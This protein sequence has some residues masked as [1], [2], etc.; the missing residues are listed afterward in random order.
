MKSYIERVIAEIPQFFSH[1]SQCLFRP[2]RFIQAELAR[3]EQPD[4]ISKGVEFLILSF[5]IALF[6]SQV[7]PEATNPLAQ[8]PQDDAAFIRLAGNALFDLFMLFFAAA[9]CFGC[10]RMAGLRSSFWQFFPLFAFFAGVTLVLLV[11]ANALTNIGFIDPYVARNHIALEQFATEFRSLTEQ[12]LCF[13]DPLTG[14]LDQSKLSISA[15]QMQAVNDMQQ[16][17]SAVAQRPLAQLGLALQLLVA[18]AVVLWLVL[19]WFA[20]GAAL[21]LG[22][23]HIIMA[24]LLSTLLLFVAGFMVELMQTGSDML[25]LYRACPA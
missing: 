18:L 15:R 5:L 24:L 1:F 13:T 22:R 7:L 4:A 12:I 2:R 25:A 8:L 10:W 6:I 21:M 16:L 11:F 20:Y 19:A 9:I 17:Y 23:G 14:E 3:A